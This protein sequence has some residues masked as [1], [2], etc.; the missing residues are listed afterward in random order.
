[1][2]KLLLAGLLAGVA[3]GETH[4]QEEAKLEPF[5]LSKE[6]QSQI[7]RVQRI[8]ELF[9][10]KF[11]GWFKSVDDVPLM[12]LQLEKRI[13]KR[14]VEH[15]EK[16]TAIRTMIETAK[17]KEAEAKKAAKI[18]VFKQ[19]PLGEAM[20]LLNEKRFKEAY[21]KFY[22]LFLK[23]SENS[24][25]NFYMGLS[26]TGAKLFDEAV[27][28]FER[29]L[30]VEPNHV[31]ARL[32]LA[33]ALF[34]LRMYEEAEREFRRVLESGETP[35]EVAANIDKFLDAIEDTKIRNHFSS[36]VM[37][38][39][40]YD[41]NVNNGIG[42]NNYVIDPDVLEGGVPGEDPIGDMIHQE[43][44]SLNHI[45]DFGRLGDYFMQNS[46]TV[47][48]QNYVDTVENNILYYSLATGLGNRQESYSFGAK[49][50]Y[51]AIQI[52][53]KDV[54]S[55]TGAEIAF[56][57]P[58]SNTVIG[59]VK[60]KSQQKTFAEDSN[61]DSAFQE[62]SLGMKKSV[63][64]T[65]DLIIASVLY[66]TERAKDSAA[67]DRDIVGLKGGYTWVYN[68]RHSFNGTLGYKI[69][70]YPEA[71]LDENLEMTARADNQLNLSV[72]NTYKYSKQTMINGSVSYVDNTSSHAPYDYNK[73]L[74]GVNVMVL[75]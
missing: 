73:M 21:E 35:E 74:A 10:V 32:E 57:M 8:K 53:A 15:E 23:D 50:H 12:N 68:D 62:L 72:G 47:F 11:P 37:A 48:G 9:M 6:E 69:F 31:R 38:G 64:G 44:A 51:D 36:A 18:E 24:R 33:R 66:S 27:S 40:Q 29:V 17:R 45:Y 2:K 63:T 7:E 30:I 46:F 75:F 13:E 61:N 41:T 54:L 70:S 42:Q 39:V 60:L 52:D 67:I 22:V 1:M 25:I 56:S 34:Y 14:K 19:T 5:T 43:M 20:M 4:A 16:Q 3:C 71:S 65:K 58:V 55:L 26:A 59:D 28:S 49:I